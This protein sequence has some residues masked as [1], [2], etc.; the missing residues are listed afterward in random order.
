MQLTLDKFK[1]TVLFTLMLLVFVV[2]PALA[3]SLEDRLPA[4]PV[5]LVTNLSLAQPD[6]LAPSEAEA[7]ETKLAKFAEETKVQIAILITDDLL[8]LDPN[9]YSTRVFNKWGIGTKDTNQGV[10]I[11]IKPTV[12]NGGRV[13]YISTGYGSEAIIPDASAKQIIEKIIKPNFK[14]GF[15]YQGLDWATDLM[16]EAFKSGNTAVVSSPKN[17]TDP[18]WVMLFILLSM[19]FWIFM[20]EKIFKNSSTTLGS[21]R[22]RR[23]GDLFLPLFFGGGGRGG[24]FGG[25]GFGGFGGGMSGGGGA[26]GSW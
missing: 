13:I 16:I 11:L 4:K 3:E 24:G 9:D 5:K 8:D 7:L 22:H 20:A 6:L 25:G 12:E 23:S 26:G 10:L 21:R 2:A 17:A 18:K 1:N 14:E 15:Y 19:F